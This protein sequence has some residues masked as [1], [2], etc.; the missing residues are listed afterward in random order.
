MLKINFLSWG[1]TIVTTGHIIVQEGELWLDIPEA[2]P[3]N[4]VM[5]K[6]GFKAYTPGKY[7]LD[8]ASM[9]RIEAE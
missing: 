9:F 2:D 1:F 4:Q 8:A 7:Y 3:A 6:R 5:E